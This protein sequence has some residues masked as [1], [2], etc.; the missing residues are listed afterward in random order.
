MT[1][2]AKMAVATS[3]NGKPKIVNK[4]VKEIA[5]PSSLLRKQLLQILPIL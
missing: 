3:T 4:M 2:G 1:K 5:L